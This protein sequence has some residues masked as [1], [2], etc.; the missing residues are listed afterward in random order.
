VTGPS[1]VG[2]MVV[3]QGTSGAVTIKPEAIAFGTSVVGTTQHR[4]VELYNQSNGLVRYR[5]QVLFDHHCDPEAAEVTFDEPA[6]T[7]NA[8][9]FKPVVVAFTGRMRADVG[10]KVVCHTVSDPNR[11]SASTQIMLMGASESMVGTSE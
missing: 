2:V 7:I 9:A 1:R 3:A 6:G 4:G 8:R 11:P 5:M 10:F